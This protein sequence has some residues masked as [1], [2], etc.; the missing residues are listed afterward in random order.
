LPL[1]SAEQE[2]PPQHRPPPEYALANPQAGAP[3]PCR[4]EA[5]LAALLSEL[6][7]HQEAPPDDSTTMLHHYYVWNEAVTEEE[8]E[9]GDNLQVTHLTVDVL[10][11]GP[12]STTQIEVEA[13]G[14]TNLKVTPTFSRFCIT[15]KPSLVYRG[16]QIALENLKEEQKKLVFS[17]KL[18]FPVDSNPCRRD[19][20]GQSNRAQGVSIGVYCHDDPTFQAGN[21]HV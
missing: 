20:W 10:L 6:S 9:R 1:T 5:N 8:Q 21:Q 11:P 4:P 16:M 12:T 13:D 14:E 17:I 19:D 15:W 18:P 2:E 7:L 3:P